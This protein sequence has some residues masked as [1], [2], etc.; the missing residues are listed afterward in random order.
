MIPK[1]CHL[2]QKEN[3]TSDDFNF[4]TIK[5]Y[6]ESSHFWRLLQK[7]KQCG[8]LYINDTVEFVDWGEGNDEIFTTII[9]VS[10]EELLKYDFSKISGPDLLENFH[11]LIF[12]APGNNIKWIRDNPFKVNNEEKYHFSTV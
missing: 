5:T 3:L 8:Q 4:E 11:P 7:C 2:W 9:P 10:E 6:W 12:W 1:N